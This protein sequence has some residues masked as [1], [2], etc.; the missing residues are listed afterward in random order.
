MS[1]FCKIFILSTIGWGVSWRNPPPL[2][3]A[4]IGGRG[5]LSNIYKAGC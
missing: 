2:F 5:I 4:E 3:V 1:L